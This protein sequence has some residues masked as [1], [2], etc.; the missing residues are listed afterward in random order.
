LKQLMDE[1]IQVGEEQG[2]VSQDAISVIFQPVVEVGTN[3]VFG[4]KT[5]ICNSKGEPC[6][7]DLY[8]KYDSLG[9]LNEL[10][11]F[12]FGVQIQKAEEMGLDRVFIN[13]DSD[14]LREIES[15]PK[16]QGTMEVVLEISDLRGL[17]EFETSQGIFIKGRAQGFQFA[18]NDF[19]AGFISLPIIARLCPE[20]IKF[21]LSG[22]VQA[23]AWDELKVVSENLL[24]ALK[25]YS[26][27]GV[28]YTP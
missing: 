19:G 13:V 24:T 20:Y 22:M 27:K 17:G 8:R 16:P 18:I 9:R 10:K 21:D 2:L 5:L 28:V 26:R 4:Y 12:C 6:T 7:P 15:L 3:E 11:L 23:I 1:K 14:L 25:S